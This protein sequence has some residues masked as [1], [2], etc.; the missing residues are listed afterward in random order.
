MVVDSFWVVEFVRSLVTLNEV[1]ENNRSDKSQTRAM[2]PQEVK[3]RAG[4][5]TDT[6]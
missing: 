5:A 3:V 4:I 1:N 6:L 2:V